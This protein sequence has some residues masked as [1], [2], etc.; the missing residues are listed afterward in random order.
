MVGYKKP[1]HV[2]AGKPGN[3]LEN[4]L[5]FVFSNTRLVVL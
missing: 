1:Y 2:Q 3:D 4:V 5:G